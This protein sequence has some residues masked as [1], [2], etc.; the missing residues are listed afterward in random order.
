M[1][2]RPP[3][4]HAEGLRIGILVRAEVLS[5]CFRAMCFSFEKI[6]HLD[7]FFP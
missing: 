2:A 6:Y 7:Y 1:I 4:G 3:S 5:N